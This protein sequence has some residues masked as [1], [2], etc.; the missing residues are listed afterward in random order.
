MASRGGVTAREARRRVGAAGSAWSGHRARVAQCVPP[1]W[2]AR[3]AGARAWT[4]SSLTCLPSARPRVRGG[5]QPMT[6]PMS[7]AEEAPVAAIPSCDERGELVL[8]QRLRAGSR[9]GSRSRL[10]PWSA[11]SSRPPARNASTD[12]RRVLTSR[13][14]TARIS[15]SVS[16]AGLASS[17]RCRRRSR[18]C[19]G[20]RDAAHHRPH[21]GGDVGL[22]RSRRD[23]GSG[24][25]GGRAD[26]GLGVAA[27][28]AR[29]DAGAGRVPARGPAQP[30]CV[31]AFFLRF[32][33]L[34]LRFTEGFS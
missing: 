33:S 24:T 14:S 5:S 4:T 17:R 18:P 7:R 21:R 26:R 6:L 28:R 27:G 34:R 31:R 1:S 9:P 23:T 3:S 13:V 8:G 12:S 2:A 30:T 11:R 22:D 32:A 29:G 19:A 25:S 10:P 15:S 20:H 16:G